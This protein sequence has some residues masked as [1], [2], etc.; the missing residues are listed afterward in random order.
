MTIFHCHIATSLDGRIARPDGSVQDWLVE[1]G[2]PPEA[3]GF[4]AFYDSVDAILM[5]RG[6]YEAVRGMG[7][8]PYP[9][10]RVLVVTSQELRDAPPG[11]EARKGDL[12]AIVAELEGCG[13]VW[14]EGGGQ[15]LRG[16]IAIG[17]LDRLEMAVLPIILGDGIPLFPTGTPELRLALVHCAAVAGGAL[18]LVY[19]ARRNPEPPR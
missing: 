11:V 6:T 17:R 19:E 3:F 10:K 7:E 15:L 12:P 13:R 16:M 4:D 14:V 1:G 2:P 18:H 8:W 5:G 9:G